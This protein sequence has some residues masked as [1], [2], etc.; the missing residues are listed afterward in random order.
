MKKLFLTLAI[1]IVAS[2]SYSVKASSNNASILFK[3][4]SNYTMVLRIVGINGGLYTTVSLPAH[5]SRTVNFGNTATYKLKIKATHYGKT[6]YHDGGNFSVTCN[7]Y[8]YTEGVMSFMMSTYGTGLG[9][10]ISA[11]EF[12]SD[13]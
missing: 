8:E 4:Q 13:N 10:S 1:L 6:S 7:N 9:P 2:V 12:M 11:N 5:S 3:N